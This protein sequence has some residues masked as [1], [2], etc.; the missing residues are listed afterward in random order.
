MSKVHKTLDNSLCDTPSPAMDHHDIEFDIRPAEHHIEDIDNA[1]EP[2]LL[3]SIDPSLRD[4]ITAAYS[5]VNIH[6]KDCIDEVEEDQHGEIESLE[7]YKEFGANEHDGMFGGLS[8]DAEEEIGI[9]DISKG[10]SDRTEK[11]YKR[12]ESLFFWLT[13]YLTQQAGC[14]RASLILSKA[15]VEGLMIKPKSSTRTP[16]NQYRP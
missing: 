14:K 11:E 3:H 1:E 7:D 12:H 2:N 9:R 15:V 16:T 10:V 13:I 5:N 4:I 8:L 6:A